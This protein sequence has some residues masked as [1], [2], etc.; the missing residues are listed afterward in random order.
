[1][2]KTAIVFSLILSLSMF[3]FSCKSKPAENTV[4]EVQNTKEEVDNTIQ[5][6]K[7]EVQKTADEILTD[8]E[9]PT[10][11]DKAVND[12]C[13]DYKKIMLEY[14]KAKGSSDKDMELKLKAKLNIWAAGASKL[15]GKIK[16]GE[17]AA[18]KEFMKKAEDTLK[19]VNASDITK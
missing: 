6:S 11:A 2:K 4:P 18:F 19:E 12:F 17:S 8:I 13:G 3:I 10:F 9:V 7:E 5:E 14:A 15:A 1:M 16:P